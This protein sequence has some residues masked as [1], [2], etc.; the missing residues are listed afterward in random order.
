MVAFRNCVLCLLLIGSTCPVNAEWIFDDRFSVVPQ[1]ALII[2]ASDGGTVVSAQRVVRPGRRA[3]FTLIPAPGFEVAEASASCGGALITNNTFVIPEAEEA[4]QLTVVFRARASERTLNDT[5]I[6]RCADQAQQ[7]LSCPVSSHPNQDGDHGRDAQARNNQL[8][9]LGNGAAGFDFSKL[10]ANGN[11]LPVSASSWSCV[12]DNHSGL[13]WEV[14]VDDPDHLQYRGHTYSWYQ[15]DHSINGGDAGAAHGGVCAGSACNTDAFAAAVNARG[16]CGASDWR[17][18]SRS[19]L[20]SL[21]HQGVANPSIDTDYFPHTE[22]SLFW[23]ASPYAGNITHAW[24]VHFSTGRDS[25]SNKRS[26]S[27]V[28]LVRNS[29]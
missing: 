21:S 22:A 23:A 29:P 25:W 5:G 28:R 10:D 17:L 12:R 3:R 9:K 2:T 18:P 20:H 4:C 26:P 7:D 19:E 14:K 16:L 24:G 15:P 13:V 11:V 8:T 6:D 27:R 1:A